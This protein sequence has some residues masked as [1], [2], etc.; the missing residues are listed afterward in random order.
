MIRF[1]YRSILLIVVHSNE[2]HSSKKSDEKTS[3]FLKK[4]I[5][6]QKSSI[7]PSIETFKRKFLGS[8]TLAVDFWQLTKVLSQ[9]CTQMRPHWN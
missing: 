7:L 5:L 8:M 6:I 1:T 4:R 3:M 2:K 9:P